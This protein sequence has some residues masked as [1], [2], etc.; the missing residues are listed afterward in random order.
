MMHNSLCREV[1]EVGDA[2]KK[3]SFYDAE[4]GKEIMTLRG[5]NSKSQTS[6]KK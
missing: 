1:K 2:L 3:G 4:G 5:S 6:K